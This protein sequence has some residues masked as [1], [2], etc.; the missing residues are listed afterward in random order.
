[1]AFSLSFSDQVTL[2][3]TSVTFIASTHRIPM[4]GLATGGSY[5]E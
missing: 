5:D 4:A 2:V 1:M 3:K